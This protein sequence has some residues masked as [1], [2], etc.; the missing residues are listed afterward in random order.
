[1]AR[2][3]RTPDE[4]PAY[5][6]IVIAFWQLLAEMPFDKITVSALSKRAG[7]NHNMIYYY[8]ENIH[9]MAQ[10]LFEENLSDELL[11]DILSL[12]FYQ[13][14]NHAALIASDDKMNRI[15][16]GRL[17]ARSDSA[18]L[19]NIVKDRIQSKWLEAIATL[20]RRPLGKAIKDTLTRFACRAQ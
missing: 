9:D 13:E 6:R 19:N 11:I 5:D 10:K 2:P 14:G 17:F 4:K 18:F 8:F 15:R 7:V 1:M 20:Y 16:R 3:K 12:L